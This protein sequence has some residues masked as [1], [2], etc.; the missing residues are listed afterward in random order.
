M[1]D[2]EIA[3]MSN[4]DKVGEAMRRSLSHMPADAR[5]VV[6]GLIQPQSLAIIAGTLVVWAGS[7]LFGVGE[8]VD[9]ILFA[10]GG[11]MLGFSVFE[12]AGELFDFGHKAIN[13]RTDADLESAGQHFARAVVILGISTIQAV[14]MRGQGKTV[15]ARGR[16][17]VYPRTRLPPPPPSG[18]RLQVTRPL[19]LPGGSLG[20]TSP[21]GIIRVARN[22][23]LK[24]QRLTLLHELVHRYLSPRTGSLQQIRAELRMSAYARSALLRYLEEALAEGYAQLRIHGLTQAID[25]L[26]FPLLGGY[27]TVSQLVG[28]GLA[29]GTIVL[30][31]SLFYVTVS[32]GSMP[33]DNL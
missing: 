22:Q 2:A 32:L 6:E 31:G 18:N 8:V 11:V 21:Y 16:P 13:A 28:E 30:G 9:I 17:Q 23:S 14:L 19:N 5:G 7:H 1:T 15:I 24:E 3:R 26:R 12:G 4:T 20:D 33:K 27:V 29:I 10:V 25:A